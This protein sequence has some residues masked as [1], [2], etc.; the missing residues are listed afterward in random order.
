MKIP[1]VISLNTREAYRTA[2]I[3]V[4]STGEA[5]RKIVAEDFEWDDNLTPAPLTYFAALALSRVFHKINPLQ[6]ILQKDINMLM[7]LYP[8]D[9][10]LKFSVPYIKVSAIKINTDI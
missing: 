6:R 10:P 4:A 2:P 1:Y 8:A 7:D 9:I 5:P 3:M